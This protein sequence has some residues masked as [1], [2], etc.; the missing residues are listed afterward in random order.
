MQQI[1][2]CTAPPQYYLEFLDVM[3][4]LEVMVSPGLNGLLGQD[5]PMGP[6]GSCQENDVETQISERLRLLSGCN[7]ENC[8]RIFEVDLTT[9]VY[10]QS[11]QSETALTWIQQPNSP[12]GTCTRQGVMKA[13]FPQPREEN[14][15]CRLTFDFHLQPNSS[16]FTFDIG[17]S[18][19]VN[20][21]GGDAGTTSNAAEVHSLTASFNIFTGTRPGYVDYATNGHI[22]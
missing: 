7:C 2:H 16:G 17:D 22:P 19:T 11:S 14:Q 15:P 20:G 21:H 9:G 10:E 5:G 18:P 6:P 3:A 8:T 4:S 1:L 12:T 13:T